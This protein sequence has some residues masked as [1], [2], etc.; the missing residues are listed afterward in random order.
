M[1]KYVILL[2]FYVSLLQKHKIQKKKKNTRSNN[3]KKK[4]VEHLHYGIS[5]YMYAT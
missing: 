4:Q 3:I 5:N 2:Q 1:A